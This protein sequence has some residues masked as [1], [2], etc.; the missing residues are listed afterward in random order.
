M[1][2]SD[3]HKDDVSGLTGDIPSYLCQNEDDVIWAQQNASEK[4]FILFWE[5]WLSATDL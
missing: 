5:V 2:L 4:L 3:V 1:L